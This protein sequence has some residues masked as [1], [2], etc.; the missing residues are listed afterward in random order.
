MNR[1]TIILPEAMHEEL[2]MEAFHKH[3]SMATVIRMRLENN[4]PAAPIASAYPA[5][6][7]I[8]AIAG[9][10][11]SAGPLLTDNLDSDLYGDQG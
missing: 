7:P 3:L 6:D 10:A 2:R 9:L 5:V 4:R 11:P 1:T 8:L